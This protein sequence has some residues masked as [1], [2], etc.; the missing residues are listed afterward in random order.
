MKTC[1]IFLFRQSRE[2]DYAWEDVK[3]LFNG[4]S[5]KKLPDSPT[6]NKPSSTTTR[7][8]SLPSSS[9]SDKSPGLHSSTITGPFSVPSS[10]FH[11][12]PTLNHLLRYANMQ[13]C[14]RYKLYFAPWSK[15]WIF[16]RDTENPI[17]HTLHRVGD[18]SIKLLKNVSTS[19]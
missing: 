3:A 14:K 8:T 15:P 2:I 5:R 13:G 19:A 4:G 11:M 16:T 1:I 7:Q 10:P 17:S 18:K 6:E 9:P 12:I